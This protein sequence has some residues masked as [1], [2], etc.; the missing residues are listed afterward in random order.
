MAKVIRKIEKEFILGK[1]VLNRVPVTLQYTNAE[2]E[3]I[4]SSILKD[5]IAVEARPE[6]SSLVSGTPINCY[7]NYGGQIMNFKSRVVGISDKALL[8]DLPPEL[9]KDLGRKYSRIAQPHGISFSFSFKGERYELEFPRS[10]DFDPVEAP[11]YSPDFN[12]ENI[13][14]LIGQFRQKADE[15]SPYYRI[16]M[17]REKPPENVVE[18]LIAK[19]GKGLFVSSYNAVLPTVDPYERKRMVTQ[20]IFENYLKTEEGVEDDVVRERINE[21]FREKRGEGIVSEVYCPILFQ[22]YVIGYVYIGNRNPARPVFSIEIF[23]LFYQ[24][25]KILSYSLKMN[26]Y[27]KN[28]EKLPQDFKAQVIDMSASGLLFAQPVD[29]KICELLTPMADMVI[30]LAVDRRVISVDAKIVRRFKDATVAY[31]G[32]QYIG[33]QPEDMRF[34]FEFLYGRPFTDNDAYALEGQ[35]LQLGKASPTFP[36]F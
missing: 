3:T 22:E 30:R 5:S 26:G 18:R 14:N 28:K 33:L 31:F 16:T 6:L 27:F 10:E 17:F 8:I 20:D 24:F 12:P 34:L 36:E 9:Y 13:Q 25:S 19:T 2:T 4:L 23:D 15:I 29:A 35:M 11:E 1:V 7:F 32:T 21:L